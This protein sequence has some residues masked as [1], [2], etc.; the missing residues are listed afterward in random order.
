MKKLL[1]IVVCATLPAIAHAADI[2]PI[3]Y[4]W[5]ED[6]APA[7]HQAMVTFSL[8]ATYFDMDV[9]NGFSTTLVD[10]TNASIVVGQPDNGFDF[11]TW[12]MS[13]DVEAWLPIAGAGYLIGALEGAWV[14]DDMASVVDYPE[15]ASLAAIR[16][17]S[18]R[19]TIASLPPN[20]IVEF[21]ASSHFYRVAGLAGWGTEAAS[22]TKVGVGGYVAY[23]QLDLDSLHNNPTVP[24]RFQTIDET[25]KTWSGGLAVLGETRREMR[26]GVDVFFSGRAAALYANG[27]LD[28][29]QNVGNFYLASAYDS[30]EAFA[31]LLEGQAGFDFALGRNATVSIFG[32]ASW[33]N[34]VFKIANP[35]GTPGEGTGVVYGFPSL[36]QT[37]L[38]EYSAGGKLEITF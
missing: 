26:P 23:S 5:I 19:N 4:S 8:A 25:V 34:D 1:I 9:A 24:G 7:G 33:R 32:G 38:I 22:H 28:A 11:G 27:D 17:G 2:E 14:E 30:A 12:G 16:F 31:G 35:R 20:T 10:R 29:S 13:G 3:E 21:S 6:N 15:T 18:T 37:G 36:E